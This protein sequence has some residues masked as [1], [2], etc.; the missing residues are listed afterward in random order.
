MRKPNPTKE[1]H[2]H[3]DFNLKAVTVDNYLTLLGISPTMVA[4]KLMDVELTPPERMDMIALVF[5]AGALYGALNKKEL[6]QNVKFHKT[7]KECESIQ[8]VGQGSY[9]G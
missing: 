5:R 7:A 8:E 4:F 9:V 2:Y 1:E 3:V 6:M